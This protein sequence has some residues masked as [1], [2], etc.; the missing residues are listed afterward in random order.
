MTNYGKR[1]DGGVQGFFSGA[2]ITA[3]AKDFEFYLKSIRKLF[4]NDKLGVSQ[5]NFHFNRVT[6]VT[7]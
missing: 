3:Y 6:L 1:Y 4:R 7:P 5:Y 2:V